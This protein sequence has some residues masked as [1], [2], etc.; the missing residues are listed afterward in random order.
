MKRKVWILSARHL[1]V[2]HETLTANQLTVIAFIQ[3]SVLTT[4]KTYA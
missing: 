1:V 3:L 4:L 2:K